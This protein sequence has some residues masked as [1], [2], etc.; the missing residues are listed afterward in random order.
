L[1]SRNPFGFFSKERDYPVHA[2][3]I[4][5]PAIMPREDMGAGAFDVQGLSH[6]FERGAGTDIYMI[7]DYVPSDGGRHVHWKASA[8]TGT[9]KTRE[10]AMD[11]SH[12]I[13]LGFDRFGNAADAERF[14]RLVSHAASLA[15]HWIHDGAEVD[16]VSDEWSAPKGAKSG[17]LLD[18]ILNYLALVQMSESAHSPNIERIPG[19]I[20]LSLRHRRGHTEWDLGTGLR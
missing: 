4:C 11:E 12:R 5:Y 16:L 7:R 2:K 6:R 9:L 13:V 14:E 3:C 1:A 20:L 17:P 15:F 8:K 10:F 19:A 18:A